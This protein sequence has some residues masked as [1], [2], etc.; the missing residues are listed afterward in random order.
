M[1]CCSRSYQSFTETSS[2]IGRELAGMAEMRGRVPA[3]ELHEVMKK[4]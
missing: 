2:D 1:H 4:C 3:V